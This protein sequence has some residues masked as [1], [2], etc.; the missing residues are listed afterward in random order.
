MM[1]LD[2]YSTKHMAILYHHGRTNAQIFLPTN[3]S[4]H[5]FPLH[6]SR[7]P[8]FFIIDQRKLVNRITMNSHQ[9]KWINHEIVGLRQLQNGINFQVVA[10]STSTNLP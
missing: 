4:K 9:D 10:A 2:G 1:S 8:K 7:L 6:F 3:V 5:L